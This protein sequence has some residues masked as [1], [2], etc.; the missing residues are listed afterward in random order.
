MIAW[1]RYLWRVFHWW[2]RC[3]W[4]GKIVPRKL[5]G[6]PYSRGYMR[7]AWRDRLRSLDR[8]VNARKTSH[9]QRDVAYLLLD[10]RMMV[11]KRRHFRFE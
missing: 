1:L 11:M 3:L 6:A 2:F 5:P 4:E 10:R 9:P 7:K 8:D